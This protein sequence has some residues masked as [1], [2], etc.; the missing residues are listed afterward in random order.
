MLAEHA[1]AA[2]RPE[3]Q[4]RGERGVRLRRPR[5]PGR[6]RVRAGRERAAEPRGAGGAM[7]PQLEARDDAEVAAAPAAQRPEQVLVAA[8]VDPAQPAVGRH[9][10][11]AG[12]VVG[13]QAPG[14]RGEAVA[15]AEREAAEPDRRAGPE[16]HRPAAAGERVGDLDRLRA[17]ADRR[18]AAAAVDRDPAQAPQ[19]DDHALAE[20]RVARV[21]VPAR[22]R[23]DAHVVAV[24]PPQQRLHVARVA[25]LDHGIGPRAVEARVVDLSGAREPRRAGSQHRAAHAPGELAQRARPRA[26][27]AAGARRDPARVARGHRQRVGRAEHGRAGGQHQL[28]AAQA[29][30][31]FRVAG[32][33]APWRRRAARCPDPRRARTAARRRA[34]CGLPRGRARGA[35][36][37]RRTA[38]A[39]RG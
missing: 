5:L 19:V 29:L 33:R 21:G 1:H 3:L 37:A 6:D 23:G 28:A 25:R 16:R 15:A 36:R 18:A 2:V 7:H 27:G 22:A 4:Q 11:D 10:H 13:G 39:S 12:H 9:H 34:R 17:R 14:A 35:R 30:H 20:R 32:G 8:P 26:A 31:A 38:R 24:R